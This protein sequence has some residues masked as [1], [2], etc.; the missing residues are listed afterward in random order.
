[1]LAAGTLTGFVPGVLSSLVASILFVVLL[2]FTK[3]FRPTLAVIGS[4]FKLHRCLH[5][6]QLTR[7]TRSREDYNS[8]RTHA[9]T[10]DAYVSTAHHQLQMISISLATGITFD[11][12]C[13]S[14][15]QLVERNTPVD[16]AI[17]LLDP[18]IDGLMSAIAPALDTT[19]DQLASSIGSALDRLCTLRRELPANAKRHLSIYV[20]R[21]VPF[22]SAILI[23]PDEPTGVIQLEMKA[24]RVPFKSSF[25]FELKNG[26]KHQLYST[27]VTAY[28]SLL[29]DAEEVTDWTFCATALKNQPG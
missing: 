8:F 17:S 23:D 26:G 12:L 2:V 5:E 9:P 27:L 21:A 4:I 1:M 15:R 6:I 7:F 22:A 20:H 10:I 28:R 3:G 13:R 29:H 19:P 11:G 14:L 16:V 25:G 24:Y 18:R